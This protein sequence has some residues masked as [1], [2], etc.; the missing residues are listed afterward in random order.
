M[1][2]TTTAGLA[3]TLYVTLAL[4]IVF[5]TGYVVRLKIKIKKLRKSFNDV[6]KA[7]SAKTAESI[8]NKDDIYLRL[9]KDLKI[10]FIN[11]TALQF[12]QFTESEILNQP[13][14]GRI[15]DDT[16]ANLEYLQNWMERIRK[17]PET[18]NSEITVARKNGNHAVMR[19]RIRPVLDE[20]LNP[21][22]MSIVLRDSSEAKKLK[23]KLLSLTNRDV[24]ISNIL[25]ENALY[26]QIEKE[27]NRCKRYNQEFSLVVLE[28]R[29]IYDFISK[30]I[31]FETGDKLI[32]KAAQ[33]CR[34]TAG[35]DRT[36]GRFDKTKF[37]IALPKTSRET[38]SQTAENMYYPLIKMIQGLGVDSANAEMLAISYTNRKNFNETVD[39]LLGRV[40]RH[41]ASALKKREYGIKSSDKK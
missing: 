36:V 1:I 26:K 33:I 41:I 14:L 31:D 12:F 38:A 35:K 2:P 30:G 28:L 17:S 25:N 34:M 39:T 7:I 8:Q 19:I 4:I 18:I 10:E 29:D 21:E 32:K 27:F 22:G 40:N 6:L 15:M 16:A 5:L 13:A 3:M 37:A 11:D 24:L 20:V 9:D 23:N